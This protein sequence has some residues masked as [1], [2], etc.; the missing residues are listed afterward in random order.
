MSIMPCCALL[1]CTAPQ[2]NKDADSPADGGTAAPSEATSGRGRRG[3]F[4]DARSMLWRAFWAAHQRFFRH[5][6]M[7]AKVRMCAQVHAVCVCVWLGVAGGVSEWVGEVWLN[8][9]WL[10]CGAVAAPFWPPPPL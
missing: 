9:C 5:M 2:A 6:C 8:L 10:F 7:A 1:C 4:G 3:G